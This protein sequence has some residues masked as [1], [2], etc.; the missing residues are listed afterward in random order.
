MNARTRILVGVSILALGGATLWLA[1]TQGEDDVRFVEDVLRRPA[2]HTAGSYTLMGVPQPAQVPL[3]G[4][5][6][7]FLAPNPHAGNETVRTV[8]WL[9]EGQPAH[10]IHTLRAE[11]AANGSLQWTF[12]NET[13]RPGDPNAL[14]PVVE[15][16]WTLG[17]AGE[18]FPVLGFSPDG[19]V[20]PHTPRVWALYTQAPENPIQPKPSQFTGRLMTALPDGSPL[21]EGALIYEVTQYTAGCSSKFL[22]PAYQEDTS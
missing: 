1:A 15:S 21:P 19:Q 9:H 8:A 3:T 16:A 12:R 2:E 10:S 7:T 22:P 17:R 4:P 6:G 5:S 14:L 13:H 20:H 18:A 11:V